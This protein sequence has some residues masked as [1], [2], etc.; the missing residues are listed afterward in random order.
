MKVAW[1]VWE[2]EDDDYPKLVPE[3]SDILRWCHRKV[4]IGYFE[5]QEQ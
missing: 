5:V 3:D 2:Y 1:L 4:R